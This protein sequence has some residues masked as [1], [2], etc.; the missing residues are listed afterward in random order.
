MKLKNALFVLILSIISL[1][2]QEKEQ[3]FLSL[4]QTGVEEFLQKHPKFDGRGT[5]VFVFDTGVDM[6]ID[7]LLKTANGDV[8]VIDVQDFTGQGD[9]KFYA[10]EIEEKDGKKY[11]ENEEMKFSVLG[12]EKLSLK[13][14]DDEYFIGAINEDFWKNSSSNIQDINGNGKKDDV[15]YFV[16]FQVNEG[17]EKYWVVYFD[18]NSNGDLSDEKPIRTYKEKQDA[19]AILNGDKLPQLTMGLNIFPEEKIV[20]F[21]FDDGGHGTHV[22][23]IATGNDIGGVG[24]NGVAPGANVISC[25]LGNNNFSGGATVTES[26]KKAYLYADK[27]SKETKSYCVINMSFGV[28]SEFEGNAE[29]EKF[30]D[31]LVKNNPYLYIAVSNGNEGPGISTSG[32]PAASSSVLSS[33][34]VLTKEVG[35]DLYG[36]DLDNDII[37]YFSSRGGE[38]SKPDILAPGACTSTV[39]NWGGN[40]RFWGT[41]MASP[42]S[43]GVLS[44]IMSAVKEEYPD[45]KI[46]SLL[47]YKAI[48]ESATKWAQYSNIDQG[49]GF[50]N[51]DK[52]YE[53]LKKYIKDGEIEKF[54]TYSITAIAPNMENGKAPNLYLRNGLYLTGNETYSFYVERNN[55]AGKDKFYRVYNVVSD[56]D[57]LIPMQKKTYLRNDQAT[58]I[59]VRFDKSK[60]Q[61][62]GMYNARIK[63][64]REGSDKYTEFEM[65]ATV[66]IPEEFTK[67][68]NY[69]KTWSGELNKAMFERYF[70]NVPAG[71]TSMK[72]KLSS[73]EGKYLSGRFDLH[74]PDGRELDVTNTVTSEKDM[75]EIE[76]TYMNL[77][78]GV[79]ELVVESSFLAK[80]KSTYNLAVEFNGINLVGSNQVCENKKS[81]E[82]INYFNGVHTYGLTGEIS[83][84]EKTYYVTIKG[85]D[86]YTA[87]FTLNEN[88]TERNFKIELTKDDFN[89]ITDFAVLAYNTD[90][91][92][93][94]KDGLSYRTGELTVINDSKE[95]KSEFKLALI[96]G[97]ANADGE[98]TVKI[99]EKT[100]FANPISVDVKAKNRKSVMLFP[101][102]TE[103]LNL[104]YKLPELTIP[105]ESKLFGTVRFE[106]PTTSTVEYEIP[107]KVNK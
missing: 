84:Y 48:R 99:T 65:M 102:I 96:P 56:N 24:L 70:L 42:Y 94:E 20:N 4:R 77:V 14:L 98:L 61:K 29:M 22:A 38:V 25:K 78:P 81:I 58:G 12:A 97:F 37:L 5:I 64:Y 76:R 36:T 19:V 93:V 101:S 104:N 34:A 49:A 103:V 59:N 100:Y 54:E 66:I 7:G 95:G 86:Y 62:P 60:M 28:G 43:A 79:Y 80:N 39:P 31:E 57:W 74:A 92:A 1:Y 90:G 10:A 6:G 52:A 72:V 30:I 32:L 11:F 69:R 68:N 75:S 55:F 83:G 89:K 82:V 33:G 27:V 91:V 51:V 16:V 67:E 45:V 3:T 73:I 41:S 88:E 44:L 21:H 71:A 107:I 35:S 15:F 63:A 8:K 105:E 50:I 13:A 40:D 47:V 53:L 2:G 46:P 87:P 17:N 85:K 18:T 26:M 23:G 106:N 9:I